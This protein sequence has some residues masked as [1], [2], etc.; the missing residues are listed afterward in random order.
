MAWQ[1]P[2][3]Y[4]VSLT[5]RPKGR[6]KRINRM[7]SDLFMQGMT[8][9]TQRTIEKRYFGDGAGAAKAVTSAK[10]E[11]EVFWMQGG[12]IGNG[13]SHLWHVFSA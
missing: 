7:L 2:N 10:T 8:G 5:H 9:N 11:C 12:G 3:S 13:R 6:Q 1:L 4:T